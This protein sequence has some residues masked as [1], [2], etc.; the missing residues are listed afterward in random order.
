MNTA[1]PL[2][3]CSENESSIL[4]LGF[5][6]CYT[7]YVLYLSIFGKKNRN[8]RVAVFHSLKQ[9]KI[10]EGVVYNKYLQQILLRVWIRVTTEPLRI[11]TTVI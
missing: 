10:I 8:T 9:L 6:P 2:V 11:G 1:V 5:P 7:T 3:S 4:K